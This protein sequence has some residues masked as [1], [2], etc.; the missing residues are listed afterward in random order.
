[1]DEAQAYQKL[2][3]EY[4]ANQEWRLNNLYHIRDKNGQKVLLK[5]N[6]AQ[7]SFLAVI[8]YF[9]VILKAR[10][11]GFSTIIC[12]Y[13]LDCA[14]FNSN[15]KCG[16]I[17]SGI[18][19]AKK[20][21]KMIKYAYEN[22]P[23]D[24]LNNP[25]IGIPTMTTNAAELVEFSNGSGISVGTSHRGDTLQKLLISEYGK[26]SAATPEKAREIKTGALNAVGIGQQI[27]VE[28]TAEGKAGEFYEL[29]QA[30]IHLKNSG[31]ILSR[32]DPKFHFFAW[33]NNPEY[34]LSDEETA[35]AVIPQEIEMYLSAFSLDPNQKAWY[36]VKERM[37][38]EDMRRE[39]PSTPE[40]AFEGSA[41]G[42]YYSKEMAELRKSGQIAFVPYD[43]S[44]PVHTYWD[45]GKTRDQS[46]IIFFQEIKNRKC[47]IDYEEKT[48]IAWDSYATILKERG[49]NY[50]THWWPHDGNHS[51]ITQSEVL[52]AR[53][54]AQRA[55]INPIKVIPVTKSIHDDVK[56]YCKP[57]LPQVWIDEKKCALLITRLDS[58][59]RRWDK[60]N[61]MWMNEAQHDEA[62]HGCLV[63]ET[64]VLTRFGTYPIMSLPKTG[65]VMTLW[66]W[67]KYNN[68]HITRRNAELVEIRF[69]DGSTVKCTPEHYFLTE[70]GWSYAKDLVRGSIIQSHLT[71]L[72]NTLMGNF[73]GF[74]RRPFTLNATSG[75]IELFGGAHLAKF[76]QSIMC[77][78][79]TVTRPTTRC[80]TLSVYRQH[81]IAKL[82]GVK[83]IVTGKNTSQMKPVCLPQYG[84]LP[85]LEGCG[86]VET[87]LKQSHTSNG[88]ERKGHANVVAMNSMRLSGT[89]EPE[90]RNGVR[91]N[92]N[93]V[94]VDSVIPIEEKQDVW[95]LTV[96]DAGQFS[97]GNGAIVKNS[98]A[99]RTFAVQQ[100]KH[101][102]N[103]L[104]KLVEP[105]YYAQTSYHRN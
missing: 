28:S 4:L 55:G 13:F 103:T 101:I 85:T 36:A 7:R 87:L 33:F 24:I 75:F 60:V 104:A 45:L 44:Y 11:L 3:D 38:G 48:N 54:M 53:Q 72:R 100:A 51:S 76:L 77:T 83:S 89:E 99:F 32:L 15:H 8:W 50:G 97:L 17:D 21:L 57:M 41:E 58:Y 26:V 35:L 81:I 91:R 67:K 9:N 71:H 98:D 6:W 84:T 68:V 73:I 64:E 46:S 20:K 92:A 10:Q 42:A 37:M 49:Y 25:K 94:V 5:F 1:M 80:T 82:H 19:D 47:F 70:S 69:K 14:L 62:S 95:C 27:F 39:Y 16:I 90:T 29:C 66:G 79:K 22:I 93:L 18:D 65:E 96:P 88:S 63:G 34:R 52:T 105:G 23:K 61:A 12:I 74:S 43:R 102:D 86:I 31:K 2:R 59:R 56:N 40:E 78:I 30:A